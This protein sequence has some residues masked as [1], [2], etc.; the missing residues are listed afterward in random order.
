[1]IDETITELTPMIGVKAACEAVGRPR[2][3]HYRHHR[4]SPPP[5]PPAVKEPARKVSTLLGQLLMLVVE[6][7]GSVGWLIQAA[8]GWA[9]GVGGCRTN[10]SGWA[11]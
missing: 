3:T 10:R 6:F 7:A 1:M 5:A 8:V 2:A 4:Q 9:C 11:V